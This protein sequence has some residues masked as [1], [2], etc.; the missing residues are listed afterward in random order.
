MEIPRMIYAPPDEHESSP[1]PIAGKKCPNPQCDKTVYVEMNVSLGMTNSQFIQNTE[2]EWYKNKIGDKIYYRN[3]IYEIA[4]KE[5]RTSNDSS[6]NKVPTLVLY[7]RSLSRFDNIAP[8]NN[9]VCK[10][11][12]DNSLSLIDSKTMKNEPPWYETWTE[13]Q[14]R[15]IMDKRVGL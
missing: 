12:K 2:V 11:K 8:Y 14:L 3:F 5:V 6:I 10:V 1:T 9:I 15:K 7:L 13:D 4:F